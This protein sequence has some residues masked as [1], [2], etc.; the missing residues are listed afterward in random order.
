MVTRNI[1]TQVLEI[2]KHTKLERKDPAAWEK[3]EKL[4]KKI[5]KEWKSSKTSWQLI[6]EGRR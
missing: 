3:L 5:S 4:G 1:E 2:K 6:S